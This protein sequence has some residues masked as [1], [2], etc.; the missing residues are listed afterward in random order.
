MPADTIPPRAVPTGI[1]LRPDSSRVVARLFVPGLEEVGPTGSRASAV[2]DRLLNLD[3]KDC[4]DA[5]EDVLDRFSTRHRD[6][7][8]LFARNAER[9]LTLIDPGVEISP[10]RRSLIGACFTHEYSIE[11][12]ALCNPSMVL[13]PDAEESDGSARFVMSVRGI[14]E[15]HRSSIGFRTGR[16][17]ADGQ[18]TVHDPAPYATTVNGTPGTH[19]RSV[20]HS[21]L[22]L[23]GDDFTSVSQFVATL[24]PTFDDAELAKAVADA[25]SDLTI[26]RLDPTTLG[27]VT[28]L[29]HWSYVVEFPDDTHLSERVL[30][31]HA[32]PEYHGMED[33][34]FVR[35]VND[36]G[37][38][39]YFGTYTAFDR[40]S[41]SLQ[42][43]ETRDFRV[44]AS[45]PIAGA[46]A[47]GK[48]LAIFPRKI[49]GRFWALTRADRETNGIASSEDIRHWPTSQFRSRRPRS[50]GSCC[51]SATADRRSRRRRGGSSSRTG[52]GPCA[53]TASGPCCWIWTTRPG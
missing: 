5:L 25:M 41:I 16:I 17:T 14:G 22:D 32:P 48:G 28:E 3:E 12:A 19:Y 6:I 49:N 38:V 50:H 43:L 36:E 31:P 21:K 11:A 29:S 34:R 4:M 39:I 24:P 30:W 13:Q 9:V 10:A 45:S 8:G 15:G 42:L 18:V 2:I 27:H 35:F 23:L 44:F 37:E 40:G 47:E 53:P 46:A 1:E 52:S 20:F 51:S 7:E 26:H 33:A